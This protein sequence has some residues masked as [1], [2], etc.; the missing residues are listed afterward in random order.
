LE[1]VYG[2]QV[3]KAKERDKKQKTSVKDSVKAMKAAQIAAKAK[4]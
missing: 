4:K 2:R 1:G 3:T